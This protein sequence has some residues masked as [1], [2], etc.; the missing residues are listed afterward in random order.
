MTGGDGAILVFQSTTALDL[1]GAL[2]EIPPPASVAA[3]AEESD[4]VIRVFEEADERTLTTSVDVDDITPAGAV[5]PTAWANLPAG[6]VV[7]SHLIHFD[8]VGQPAAGVTLGG[9]VTFPSDILGVIFNDATLDASDGALGAAGTLYPLGLVARGLDV[10]DGITLGADR[11][12]L[13]ITLTV[14]TVIDQIRVITAR[15]TEPAAES[16]FDTDAE[17][18]TMF[19][20]ANGPFY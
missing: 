18:W 1:T 6:A 7:D 12:T 19:A 20:D 4:L 17:S 3:Q 10:G 11:R 5:L 15:S 8:P 14:T 13:N 2:A 9:S 16:R